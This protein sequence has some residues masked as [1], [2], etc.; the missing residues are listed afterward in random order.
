MDIFREVTVTVTVIS[1]KRGHYLSEQSESE[2]L[3]FSQI[4]VQNI[5]P[6]HLV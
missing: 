4:S 6:W 5:L 1:L 3:N 2:E